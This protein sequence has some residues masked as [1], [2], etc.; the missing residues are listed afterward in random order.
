MKIPKWF[1]GWCWAIVIT[2]VAG[3]AGVIVSSCATDNERSERLR[4][5]PEWQEVARGL[6]RV[7]VGEYVCFT[8]YSHEL[9]CVHK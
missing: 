2:A 3:T 1:D 7:E 5:A 4:N 6:Y 9:S 8:R